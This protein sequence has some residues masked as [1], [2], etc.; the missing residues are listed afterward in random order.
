MQLPARRKFL[1]YILLK[2]KFIFNS[3]YNDFT[4]IT[5]V[6]DEKMPK[7]FDPQ[8]IVLYFKLKTY[9][10]G[11]NI[12]V[13]VNFCRLLYCKIRNKAKIIVIFPLIPQ[14]IFSI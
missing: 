13:L 11:Q 4:N 5:P 6:F 12:F 3:Y 2:G 14:N 7:I 10:I 8:V 1:R 9:T